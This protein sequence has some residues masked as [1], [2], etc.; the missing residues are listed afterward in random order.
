MRLRE[1]GEE[2]G[3]GHG[4]SSDKTAA[5]KSRRQASEAEVLL[6]QEAAKTSGRGSRA[7]EDVGDAGEPVGPIVAFSFLLFTPFAHFLSF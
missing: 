5:E 7:V 1:R 4:S 6:S 2:E 3:R